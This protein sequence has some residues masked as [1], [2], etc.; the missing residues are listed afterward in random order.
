MFDLHGGCLRPKDNFQDN[1][2]TI[3]AQ[4][5]METDGGGWTVILRRKQDTTPRINFKRPF[6]DYE[7]GFGNLK[8][9][10]W[11]GLSKIHC[12]TQRNDVELRIELNNDD[13]TGKNLTYDTFKIA[14]PEDNYRLTI[15]SS[16]GPGFDPMAQS[17]GQVFSAYDRDNDGWYRLNCALDTSQGNGGGWWYHVV[18]DRC[19]HTY[20]TRPAAISPSSNPC[21]Y[22]GRDFFCYSNVEMKIRVKGCH[23]SPCALE[24]IKD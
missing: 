13:D 5:D 17:N 6:E 16:A 3:K 15:V 9:E 7:E 22:D 20:L 24:T 14:G 21:V 19:S 11:Y 1:H 12:L 8:T 18:N 23:V 2:P 4:C 10:F